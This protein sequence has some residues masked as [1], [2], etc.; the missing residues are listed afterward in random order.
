MS[1]WKAAKFKQKASYPG[2]TDFGR[3][4]KY[5]HG[6]NTLTWQNL[7]FYGF[8]TNLCEGRVC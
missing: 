1:V 2:Y 5:L 6:L 4:I 3:T 7:Y 8:G